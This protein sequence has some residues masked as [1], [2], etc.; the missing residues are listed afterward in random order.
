[1][2][3]PSRPEGHQSFA[4]EPRSLRGNH[5]GKSPLSLVGL[6][7]EVQHALKFSP[8]K[9]CK[10]PQIACLMQAPPEKIYFMKQAA[11]ALTLSVKKARKREFLRQLEEMVSRAALLELIAGSI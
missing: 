3:H 11:L 6:K 8:G 2:R 1:M 4:K 10:T 5:V 9:L 7:S